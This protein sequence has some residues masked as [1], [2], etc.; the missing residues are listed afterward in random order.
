MPEHR[1]EAARIAKTQDE[2]VEDDIDVIVLRG[3]GRTRHVAQHAQR[4]RHAE[5]HD[6]PAFDGFEQQILAAPLDLLD[7]QMPERLRQMRRDRPAQ[8]GRAHIDVLDAPSRDIRFDSRG[9]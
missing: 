4:A 2:F 1:A 3:V 5:M 9:G 6:Q 7:F 8:R